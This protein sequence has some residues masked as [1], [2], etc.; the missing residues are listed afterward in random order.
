MAAS[1]ASVSRLPSPASTSSR[2][3]SVSSNVKFPELPDAKMEIRKPID[4]LQRLAKQ[5]R[6]W[7][8]PN[9]GRAYSTRQRL[10]TKNK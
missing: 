6:K 5:Q 1:L 10:M 7:N 8:F 4:A 2:V 9:H 3:C